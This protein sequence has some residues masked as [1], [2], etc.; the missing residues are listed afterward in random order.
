MILQLGPVRTLA[1]DGKNDIITNRKV[2][3]DERGIDNLNRLVGCKI[4]KF[5]GGD[6]VESVVFFDCI[7]E[8]GIR[9]GSGNVTNISRV[10]RA[11]KRNKEGLAGNESGVR[12]GYVAG[13]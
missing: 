6:K 5:I 2:G 1:K 7:R 12:G 9:D 3:R 4:P 11:C 8:I 13:F 10:A